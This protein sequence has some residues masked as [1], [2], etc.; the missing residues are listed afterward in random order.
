MN[1]VT[2]ATTSRRLRVAR[3]GL[4]GLSVAGLVGVTAING[5]AG[6][7]AADTTNPY[8]NL[9][10]LETGTSNQI[11]YYPAAIEVPHVHQVLANNKGC[12]LS[13]T[14]SAGPVVS[15]T[16]STPG[17]TNTY[18]GFNAG[19]I[20]V[21]AKS[22]DDRSDNNGQACSQVNVISSTLGGESLTLQLPATQLDDTAQT[23]LY[24]VLDVEVQK[25]VVIQATATLGNGLARTFTLY[26]GKS[27]VPALLPSTDAVCKIGSTSSGPN[28]SSSDN[29]KWRISDGQPFDKLILKATSKGLFS[30]E[31]GADWPG[32]PKANADGL[33]TN[34]TYF[35]LGVPCPTT[36]DPIDV[37][38]GG[39]GTAT[40][41]TVARL[42]DNADGSTCIK[43]P[44][45]VAVQTG[46]DVVLTKS[47]GQPFAQYLLS[48]EWTANAG[49]PIKTTTVDFGL[50][51]V[52]GQ[53]DMPW[54]PDSVLNSD[55]TAK[56]LTSAAE[57]AAAALPD[58]DFATSTGPV[59]DNGMVQYACIYDKNVSYASTPGTYTI[60]DS[61]YLLGDVAMRG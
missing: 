48:L 7:A 18:V 50:N 20:G 25:D 30:L 23:A 16:G 56:G 27:V 17:S 46:N 49:G 22:T 39:V 11:T 29:C 45:A 61:I 53:V 9:I 38:F 59:A 21:P 36:P 40:G 57:F 44:V 3:F 12:Y 15:L 33:P 26:T 60:T 14:S 47:A 37:S 43:T 35:S 19:S 28:S 34:A 8:S 51:G 2:S 4:I 58:Q 6:P 24:G 55:G 10:V 5:A 31:G 52:N 13:A 32:G 54:C 41:S 42:P 1:A